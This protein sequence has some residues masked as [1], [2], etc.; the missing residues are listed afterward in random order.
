MNTHLGAVL[1][2]APDLAYLEASIASVVDQVRRVKMEATESVEQSSES[3]HDN[4]SFEETQ[5]Q[6]KMLLNHLGGLS[7]ARERALEVEAST[8]P[9]HADVGT[10][11]EYTDSAGGTHTTGIGS[12][13]VSGTLF[14][15][16]FVSYQSPLGKLL[17]G[18]LVGEQ[19]HGKIGGIELNLTVT[20]VHSGRAL[21]ESLFAT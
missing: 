2:L 18:A 8:H 13:M 15:A 16:G 14:E 11:V 19:R 5:R 20:A 21:I 9:T 1:F 12:Y 6:L 7:K 3:W 17:Y 4:Y 10:L